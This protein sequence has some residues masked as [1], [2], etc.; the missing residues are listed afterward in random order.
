MNTT[1]KSDTKARI[2]VVDDEPGIRDFLQEFFAQK[3][4]KVHVASDGAQALAVLRSHVFHL[5]MI[6]LTLPDMSGFDVSRQ[7]KEADPDV[8]TIVMS[9][10]PVES[11]DELQRNRVDEYLNK[12]FSSDDLDPLMEK[13]GEPR[14]PE[15]PDQAS[16]E[17]LPLDEVRSRF[18]YEAGHQLKAPLAVLKEFAY[19][20]QEGFGG[21][22][23][24][25]QQVY[26]DAIHKNIDRLLYLVDNI[27]KMSRLDSGSWLIRLEDADPGQ[28]VRHV[29][30]S[31]RPILEGREQELTE[32][33]ADD[34]PQIKADASAVEQVLFNL[35]DNAS[36]YGPPKEV[37]KLRCYRPD[38]H[39]VRIE[40][41]DQ[42]PGVPE[43]RRESIFQPFNRL[44]EHES[45]PGLGL[46][47]AVA[48]GL[49][50]RMGGELGLDT[51]DK[52]G[53][54]FYVQFRV[55]GSDH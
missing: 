41:E 36:K 3:G 8:V 46:G 10:L 54:R 31:W 43:D 7:A 51:S 18:F 52:P 4:F 28:I 16:Q 5:A 26:L 19:L 38:E 35:I 45:A 27:D 11:P 9:G 49:I 48:Q 24:E 30:E 47:L 2:L 15:D 20:F 1:S 53:S 6:D 34:L 55:A 14:P 32:D 44:P 13:Y 39:H 50:Q 23:S 22:L 17:R 12:P 42:G 25:K 37:V 21:E 29:A 33:I 40:V